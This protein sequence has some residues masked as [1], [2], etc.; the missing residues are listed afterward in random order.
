M[1]YG[2]GQS[3]R[4][5]L[6]KKSL[7]LRRNHPMSVSQIIEQLAATIGSEVYLD[8]A[9][10]HLYLTDAKLH[11]PM[12][13]KFYPLLQDGEVTADD[14]AKVL[15][16]ITVTI[17]AGQRSLPIGEFIPANCQRQLLN[18]LQDF[19]RDYL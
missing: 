19:R 17:G 2:V 7:T 10:W 15:Q 3:W 9:K 11:T 13:E 14:I 5:G 4:M 1:G 18:I 8:I 12:A 6:V 16:E